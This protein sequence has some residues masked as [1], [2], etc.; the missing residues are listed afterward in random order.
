V[1]KSLSSVEA[2]G[3]AT[4]IASDKTGTITRNE[5]TITAAY[6]EGKNYRITGT[7]YN[8]KAKSSTNRAE[9]MNDGTLGEAKILFLAGFLSSTGTVNPPDEFHPEYLCARRP[10][11]SGVCHAAHEGGL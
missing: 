5:M 9:V 6:F 7:G 11:R 2:L 8:P 4:V 10:D 1:V 3:A